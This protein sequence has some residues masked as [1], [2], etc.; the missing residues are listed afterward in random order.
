M[1]IAVAAD[2]AGDDLKEKAKAGLV[3]N[4]EAT[5]KSE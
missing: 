2:Y 5:C 1:R 3:R 4:E